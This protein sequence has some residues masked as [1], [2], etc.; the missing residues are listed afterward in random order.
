[1]FRRWTKMTASF[2]W[3]DGSERQRRQMKD[4]LSQFKEQGTRDELGL[5]VIRDAFADLL[6]P[7]TGALQTRARYFLFVPW[8]YH[9]FE[10]K[11]VPASEVDRRGRQYEL[12]LIDV[13][14]ESATAA[15]ETGVIGLRAR[16]RLQR[17]PSN[18]YW[19]GLRRLRILQFHGT[20]E[21]FHQRF[22]RLWSNERSARNDDG[23]LLV[24]ARLGF[25]GLP[26]APMEFPEKTAF[27]LTRVEADYLR[28]RV[29]QSAP[30]SFFAWWLDRDMPGLEAGFAWE[31]VSE[32]DLPAHLARQIR[33]AHAFSL[34]MQGATVLYNLLLTSLRKDTKRASELADV[35]DQWHGRFT[36]QRPLLA[37]WHLPDF[38]LC[39]AEG[40]GRIGAQTREFVE[41]WFRLA[42]EASAPEVLRRSPQ[43]RDL[44]EQREWALKKGLA[45]FRNPRALE[46]WGGAS[47]LGAMDFRWASAVVL[48]QDIAKGLVRQS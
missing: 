15:G 23:E 46:L 27:E 13:L 2:T 7:G 25:R 6:F 10:R 19:S 36:A 41:R 1:M 30:K 9:E 35:F 38:W 32:S 18:I 43:S 40:G 45:R 17:L 26:P 11:R 44:L 21:Q 31:A 28:E 20:Q 4:I 33:H 34:T 47:G 5:S 37:D 42:F 16:R 48:G 8:M 12:K 24:N 39:V 22:E 14:V 29:Q 3:L